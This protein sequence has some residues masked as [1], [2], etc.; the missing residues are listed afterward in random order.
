MYSPKDNSFFYNRPKLEV[1]Q[2]SINSCMDKQIMYSY[3]GTLLSEKE[4]QNTG[5]D[6]PEINLKTCQAKESLQR[7]SV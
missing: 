3:N 5:V 2:V 7:C 6:K 1:T 4:K